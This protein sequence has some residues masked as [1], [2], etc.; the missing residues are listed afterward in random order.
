M[1]LIKNGAA[2]CTGW[3]ASCENHIITNQHCVGSQAELEQIEFQFE[4]KRPGCGTGTASVELQ[5]QGGTLLDVDAGLDYALIMPALAGH[6]PQATY[7]FMQL[8]TRLPDVGE[9]MYIPGHPSGDPKRLS[10]ESTDPNDPGLCDVHSVS[11]P[12][13]TG[14]PVPDVGYFCDTEGGS[15]GSPVLSY[16]THKVIALHHCAACPNRGVPIVDVLASIEGS[17]N[18]LPACSTC[19]QA[20]IPQDLVASTPGDNRIFLDWSPV[21]GAVSYRI[22]RSSQSCTS[23]MEFVGTSNTPTYI[24]DTVAGGITYHYVVT[25]ISALR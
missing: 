18:P 2:H 14:G 16:Q 22:Y 25:S 12:A 1:R 17:P 21:A 4:F 23:G 9:L 6:D 20:P 19:A 24:D 5:L 7:G 10:I 15:S 3:L 8:E 11:E 13:C